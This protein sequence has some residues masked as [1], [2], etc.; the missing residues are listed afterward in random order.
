MARIEKNFEIMIIL[1]SAAAIEAVT[2]GKSL[3]FC[4]Y[5]PDPRSVCLL[6]AEE[7][8]PVVTQLVRVSFRTNCVK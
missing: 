1:S 2:P 7:S 5:W 3:R 6:A 4:G 8:S